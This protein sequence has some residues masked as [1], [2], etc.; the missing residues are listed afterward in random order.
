M[1]YS[2]TELSSKIMTFDEDNNNYKYDYVYIIQVSD[3]L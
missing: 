1:I 3:A 2:F